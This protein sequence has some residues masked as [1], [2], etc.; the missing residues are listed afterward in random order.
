MADSAIKYVGVDGCKAGWIGVGL[1]DR[2]CSQV[3]VCGKFSDLMTH[4]VD[5]CVILVDMPIGLPADGAPDYRCCDNEARELLKKKKR[6]SSV[7]HV[8]S[9][10]FVDEVMNNPDWGYRNVTM[11][12]QKRYGKANRRSK[13]L[14]DDA[15]IS[16][17]T[18][19]IIPNIDEVD[20]YLT[21]CAADSPKIRE[22]H[23]EVCFWALNGG[24]PDSAMT[25]SKKKPSG[26]DERVETLRHCARNV[27]DIDVDATY[28]K[29][30]REYTKSQVADND[31]L[32]ALALAITAKI[33]C[34]QGEFKTLPENPPTDS[35][36][37]PMEMVYAI[38][39]EK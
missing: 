29:T 37:L 5:A 27:N 2:G 16:P 28:A 7:F 20:E 1:D 11:N 21:S 33:G 25:T 6:E 35:K 10:R 18:F 9:K 38:P 30:R 22:S 14:N 26:F 24:N 3:K 19:G 4:F 34:R 39:N 23:P 12:H 13:E 17:Y 8:P 31:I 36:G 15:G 32:D